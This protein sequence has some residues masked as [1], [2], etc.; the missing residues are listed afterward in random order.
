M[1]WKPL[2]EY[3]I[4]EQYN[5]SLEG[6]VLPET[7]KLGEGDT[8]KVIAVGPGF[9]T[10]TGVLVSFDIKPND[11]VMVA[12]KVLRIPGS[13]NLLIARQTDVLAVER[14]NIPDTV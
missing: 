5:N 14:D 11:R 2:G 1:S 7:M 10:D 12:G 8:F 9:Y 6:I 13:K 4:V 3:M